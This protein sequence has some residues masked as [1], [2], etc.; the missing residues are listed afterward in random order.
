MRALVLPLVAIVALAACGPSPSTPT[1]N[2]NR[3]PGTGANAGGSRTLTL[4]KISG[5][6][7]APAGWKAGDKAPA[8]AVD[9]AA[10]KA[11][12]YALLE[13]GEAVG[14]VEVWLGSP[15]GER[16]KGP[17]VATT[18]AK[19]EFTITGIPR[20]LPYVV[21]ASVVNAKGE[22]VVSEVPGAT[23]PPTPRPPQPQPFCA[24]MPA[25][26]QQPAQPTPPPQPITISFAST[27]VVQDLLKDAG[28]A[29][30]Q[31]D[32]SA[33]GKAVAAVDAKLDV[34]ALPNL[35]DPS[36]VSN[37]LGTVQVD[38]KAVSASLDAMRAQIKATGVSAQD[39][40]AVLNGLP[41]LNVSGSGSV[42]QGGQ[43]VAGGGGE[44]TLV[45]PQG[46]DLSG[47]FGP[48]PA[49]SPSPAAAPEASASPAS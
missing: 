24:V 3:G 11:K 33:Y 23:P 4:G 48:E 49:A 29:L 21:Y 43:Q 1:N 44:G 41:T 28:N 10:A 15:K 22:V 13:K 36:A 16:Y 26:R 5:K 9:A 6:V 35:Q 31:I 39:V 32:F 17:T 12:T 47:L 20:D 18:N 42:S 14:D 30:G 37:F 2:G 34:N 46:I 25:Q 45:V 8:T 40:Q 38:G 7:I 27:L 19:G